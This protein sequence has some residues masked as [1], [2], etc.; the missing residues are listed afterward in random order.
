MYNKTKQNGKLEKEGGLMLEKIRR[1]MTK[2]KYLLRLISSCVLLF[3]IPCVLFLCLVTNRA[4]R[5]LLAANQ[6]Y[7]GKT[8]AEVST[9]L[10]EELSRMYSCAASM[11]LASRNSEKDAAALSTGRLSASPYYY[12]EAIRFIREKSVEAAYDIGVYFPQLDCLLTTSSKLSLQ[13]YA[14]KLLDRAEFSPEA[15]AELRAFFAPSSETQVRFFSTFPQQGRNGVFFIGIPQRL[16]PE[17]ASALIFFRFHSGALPAFMIEREPELQLLLL[18]RADNRVLYAAGAEYPALHSREIRALAEGTIADF[19]ASGSR[20]AV[21]YASGGLTQAVQCV[22]L[23]PFQ[24]LASGLYQFYSALRLALWG[25]LAALALLLPVLIYLNYRPIEDIRRQIGGTESESEIESIS[26]AL[27][28]MAGELNEKDLLIMDLLLANMLRGVPVPAREAERLGLLRQ[29]GQF[30]VGTT[31][32]FPLNA[33]V[34]EALSRRAEEEYGVSLYSTDI[35]RP[36]KPLLAFICL[37]GSGETDAFFSWLQAQ[38]TERL[39]ESARL[40]VGRPVCQIND[41]HL[42]YADCLSRRTDAPCAQTP[43]PLPP[44]ELKAQLLSFLQLHFANPDLSQTLVADQFALSVYSLSRFFKN[45]IGVGFSEYI[46]G[47]RLDWAQRE[48]L[49]TDRSVAEIAAA[50]GLPNANYF[51]R[52]FK[53]HFGVSPLA[54]RKNGKTRSP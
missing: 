34:Q 19:Q 54:F 30:C 38:L 26:N 1:L 52:L 12:T 10:D 6:A 27:E 35:D 18:S 16:G 3:F 53:A 20:F 15:E 5:Q 41:I 24:A 22:S 49:M 37:M 21:F 39:G 23:L 44:A 31:E 4:Y 50:A 11:A 45:Q 46:A 25:A 42:S 14:N 13:E 48:L 2:R 28:R 29:G 51:S 32:Y 17:K 36:N 8:T 33:E 9:R 7:L 47:M 40:A 43:Q